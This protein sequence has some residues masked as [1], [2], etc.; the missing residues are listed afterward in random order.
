MVLVAGDRLAAQEAS[1]DRAMK[2]STWDHRTR[3]SLQRKRS[4][5]D[6]RLRS[7]KLRHVGC[8][9]FASGERGFDV[10]LVSTSALVVHADMREELTEG[11]YAHW[12]P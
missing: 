10:F 9:T 8:R 2:H 7:D 6:K 1:N 5:Y 12:F 11:H 4:H 3:A